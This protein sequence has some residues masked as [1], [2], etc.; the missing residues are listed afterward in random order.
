MQ[1]HHS[2]TYT[3]SMGRGHIS[4]LQLLA[5]LCLVIGKGMWYW[6]TVMGR[7]PQLLWTSRALNARMKSASRTRDN[8]ARSL[9]VNIT[10]LTAVVLVNVSCLQ[11]LLL[12]AIS[13]PPKWKNKKL[14]P[15][16]LRSI[17]QEMTQC[18]FYT[19]VSKTF[20]QREKERNWMVLCE[21][22]QR[23]FAMATFEFDFDHG[24]SMWSKYGPLEAHVQLDL[25]VIAT[26]DYPNVWV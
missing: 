8:N 15:A 12:H 17:F 26:E 11:S 25:R 21:L 16:H 3:D 1:F 9:R 23:V 5:F 2:S 22:Q 18:N 6:N 13:D 10:W 19:Y 24:S 14:I 4:V 20:V 7:R